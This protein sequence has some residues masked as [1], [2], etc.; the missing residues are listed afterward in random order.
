MIRQTLLMA[1]T[2]D[3]QNRAVAAPHSGGWSESF[4]IAGTTPL[5]LTPLFVL[6][7]ARAALLASE[8]TIVGYRSQLVT[9][10]GNRLLP[11]GT[12]GG[13]LNVPGQT[14]NAIGAV[15]SALMVNLQLNGQPTTV[16]HRLAGMPDNNVVFGEYAGNNPYPG[17]LTK[18]F[19][20]LQTYGA[21]GIVRDISGNPEARVVSLAGAVLT[22]QS[23]TGAAVGDY[24]I[25]RR[26]RDENG[27]P[28]TGSYLVSA[29]AVVGGMFTY[30]LLNPPAQTVTKPNGTCRRDVLT[31]AAYTG[32]NVGRLVY[33]KIGRPFQQYR[34]RRSRTRT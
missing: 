11:G 22:T 24:I 20:V 1:L 4:Y 30:T 28:V 13:S 8:C 15:Q 21:G 12:G 29:A 17:G 23:T 9:I 5:P 14:G 26:V 25:L 33:R 2:T 6:A 3:P 32:L 10:S 18:W 31:F 27:D 16:R 7:N 19:N 34:G